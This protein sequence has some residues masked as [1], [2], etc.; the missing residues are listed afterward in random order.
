MD[1]LHQSAT[2]ENAN[3]SAQFWPLSPRYLGERIS[4][5]ARARHG[6]T[7]SQQD[8]RAH[9]GALPPQQTQGPIRQPIAPRDR[10]QENPDLIVALVDALMD[11]S[12]DACVF[13]VAQQTIL[14]MPIS[15]TCCKAT[16]Q[17]FKEQMMRPQR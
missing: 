5:S 14:G 10:P 15:W 13:I 11:R 4:F 1:D 9:D 6:S 12:A 7:S 16:L 2:L 8:A 17:V 3:P